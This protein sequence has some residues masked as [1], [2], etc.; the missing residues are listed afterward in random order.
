MQTI[1]TFV[2]RNLG[3]SVQTDGIHDIFNG[4]V[5]LRCTVFPLNIK[6]PW[7]VIIVRHDV[8]VGSGSRDLINFKAA[9][10]PIGSRCGLVDNSKILNG[11]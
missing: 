6:I 7:A 11:A 4:R 3:A 8:D 9:Q 5:S 2:E 1:R 10:E